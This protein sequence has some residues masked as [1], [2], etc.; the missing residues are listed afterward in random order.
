MQ[1]S[2][3][4][5]NQNINHRHYHHR[6]DNYMDFE[7]AFELYGEGGYLTP[8]SIAYDMACL[9]YTSPSPRDYGTSRMPSSA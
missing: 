5:A 3:S 4:F 2:Q 6:G 9:L 8:G 7:A 1:P